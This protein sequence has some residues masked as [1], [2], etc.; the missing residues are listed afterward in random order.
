MRY[1]RSYRALSAS[2]IQWLLRSQPERLGAALWPPR[3]VERAMDEGEV[4]LALRTMKQG[5]FPRRSKT[6]GSGACL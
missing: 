2:G 3:F 1:Q 6:A 4:L 5:P